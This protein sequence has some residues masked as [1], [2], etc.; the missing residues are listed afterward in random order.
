MGETI[1]VRRKRLRYQSCHRGTKEIDLMLGRFA[2][3]MLAQLT[4]EQL[5]RYETLLANPD[6]DIYLW[7]SGGEIVP[8]A[9]DSDVMTMLKN[10][11]YQAL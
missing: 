1:E 11:K 8:D 6:P 3:T 9:F 4:V 10:F 2:D 7:I 5:D